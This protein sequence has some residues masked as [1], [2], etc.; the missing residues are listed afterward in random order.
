[1]LP[2][3]TLGYVASKT[4]RK[5]SRKLESVATTA[6]YCPMHRVSMFGE[7]YGW[8]VPFVRSTTIFFALAAA[9]VRSEACSFVPRDAR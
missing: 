7:G 4:P 1:M 9:L 8:H 5:I 6:E 3:N 2:S